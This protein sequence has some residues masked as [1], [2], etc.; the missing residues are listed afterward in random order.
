MLKEGLIL[1][2]WGVAIGMAASFAATPLI[3]TFLYGVK[4]SDLLTRSLVCVFLMGIAVVATYVPGR[5][6]TQVNPMVA[7]RHE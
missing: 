6:A 2:A 7:L 3:S 4:P 1:S 5:R